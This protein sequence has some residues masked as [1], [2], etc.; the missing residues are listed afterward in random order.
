MNDDLPWGQFYEELLERG[1]PR[2]LRERLKAD[3]VDNA[4]IPG[5]D[6]NAFVDRVDKAVDHVLMT[7]NERD[8]E[9]QHDAVVALE[10]SI[11]AG[12]Q[13]P[14]RAVLLV[15]YLYAR[16]L[17]MWEETSNWD[18]IR[19]LIGA[20]SSA[21]D[22][23][24]GDLRSGDP[25]IDLVMRLMTSVD[26]GMKVESGLNCSCPVT[27]QHAANEV[28]D[29]AASVLRDLGTAPES[30]REDLLNQAKAILAERGVGPPADCKEFVGS[31]AAIDLLYFSSISSVCDAVIAYI[32][33]DPAAFTR[34]SEVIEEIAT[35][36]QLLQ[37]DVYESELRGHR[38]GLE[39]LL[40]GRNR[41]HVDLAKVIYC[42][43]FAV[44]WAEP[45]R[46]VH[47]AKTCKEKW[48][49]ADQP[50]SVDD[51]ELSDMWAGPATDGFDGVTIS[52]SEQVRILPRDKELSGHPSE[53]LRFSL[54]VRISR[55]G[56]HFVRFQQDWLE[57]SSIHDLNQAMRRAM[58]QMGDE[59]VTFGKGEWVRL[60]DLAEELIDRL[61]TDLEPKVGVEKLDRTL[62]EDQNAVRAG[63]GRVRPHLARRL[64][65]WV[66]RRRG[67]LGADEAS[68]DGPTGQPVETR[69]AFP[70]VIVTARKLSLERIGSEKDDDPFRRDISIEELR[71]A[72]GA[73]LLFHPVPQAAAVLEEWCR[74]GL[75]DLH[76][77]AMMQPLSFVGNF[78]YHTTNTTCGLLRGTPE[79]LIVEHEEAAEFVASLPVLLESWM[80]QVMKHADIADPDGDDH[81][82]EFI[83]SQQL[84][85]QQLLTKATAVMAH[86]RSPDLCLTAVHRRYLDDLME[87]AGIERL[88]R[89]LQSHFKVLDAHLELLA[90]RRAKREQE[91]RDRQTFFVGAVAVLV[92]VPSVAAVIALFDSGLNVSRTGDTIEA[93]ILTGLMALL[94]VVVLNLPGAKSAAHLL[95][96]WLKAKSRAIK[97]RL[98]TAKAWILISRDEARGKALIWQ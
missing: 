35:S 29:Q 11:K 82:P 93:L 70:H 28:V 19:S 54:E 36:E 62:N 52:F 91:T 33:G 3:S 58:R 5:E 26:S 31:R 95:R 72:K 98:A 12:I 45:D 96:E 10:E 64:R 40:D 22:S 2:G 18:D 50:A 23:S 63:R 15:T 14:H 61:A 39:G 69:K 46:L 75:P 78:A 42:Y 80:S 41:L 8:A 92:G 73:A 47:A 1:Y 66:Q 87:L 51:F 27:M 13:S 21:I 90:A 24:K 20:T 59:R 83:S 49:F 76:D 6:T 9:R 43:P 25:A 89:E 79:Y 67:V 56:N 60:A 48:V 16:Y 86:I 94:L 4:V 84:E 37:R 55:L 65:E 32:E 81:S 53:V 7:R 88:E 77:S 85:L 34:M 68:R 17:H 38:L 44:S 74:Y 71:E 30:N 57:D 97:K